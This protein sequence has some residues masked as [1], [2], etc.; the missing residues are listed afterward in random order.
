MYFN[1]STKLKLVVIALILISSMSLSLNTSSTH[2]I[3][4][5]LAFAQQNPILP[6]YK[7]NH[8][9]LESSN[10][11]NNTAKLASSEIQPNSL[12][13]YQPITPASHYYTGN[14]NEASIS[15]IPISTTNMINSTNPAGIVQPV[16]LVRYQ[17]IAPAA[18]ED[19]ITSTNSAGLEHTSTNDGS[20]H[21]SSNDNNHN[22][23]SHSDSTHHKSSSNHED[24]NHGGGTE[25]HHSS[26]RSHHF[27]GHRF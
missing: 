13:H 15:N 9:A 17:P 19:P 24:D 16:S 7:G 14:S 10:T 20:H 5:K 26:H 27:G 21:S 25:S 8:R 23:G 12:I 4:N 22:V 18:S 6:N 11:V 1:Y 3:I 2:Q